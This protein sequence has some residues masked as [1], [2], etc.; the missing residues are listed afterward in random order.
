VAQELTRMVEMVVSF[1][2]LISSSTVTESL[3]VFVKEIWIIVAAELI[4]KML[5]VVF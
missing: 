1:S 3:V 5:F 4:T 2:E